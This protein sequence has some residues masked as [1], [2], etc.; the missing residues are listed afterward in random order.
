MT[1]SVLG[2]SRAVTLQRLL[3]R[4]IVRGDYAQK[5]F[6]NESQLAEMF[7]TSRTVTR[8]AIKMLTAKGLIRSRQKTGTHVESVS[9]WNL[10]D[11]DVLSWLMDRPYSSEIYR[12]FNQVRLAIEPTA[13]ALAA[14]SS[15]REAI[16]A[17]GLALEQMKKHR[18]GSETLVQSHIDF[19]VSVLRASG[20]P[21]FWR[22][23]G[24]I[25]AA[26]SPSVDLIRKIDSVDIDMHETVQMCIAKG[27][28]SEAEIAMRR[29]IRNAGSLAEK[30]QSIKA[31]EKAGA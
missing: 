23:K 6:P 1:D 30:L 3:G 18:K 20:N 12:E 7:D 28:A 5:A 25:H 29:L 2:T 14:E 24:L 9:E 17:I 27:E 11:P 15:D 21:Y 22:L 19:H 8:E 4:A 16:E 26:L 13:A 31:R 10:L